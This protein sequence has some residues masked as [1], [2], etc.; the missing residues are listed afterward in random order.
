MIAIP[1]NYLGTFFVRVQVGRVLLPGC[2]GP[3]PP[4]AQHPLNAVFMQG[5]PGRQHVGI[6]VHGH[7]SLPRLWALSMENGGTCISG[8]AGERRKKSSPAHSPGQ[9]GKCL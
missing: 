1:T 6:N 5:M 4:G 9:K 3:T 8:D 7:K 2:H